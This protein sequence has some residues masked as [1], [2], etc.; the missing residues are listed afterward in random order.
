MVKFYIVLQMVL[1]L[2]QAVMSSKDNMNHKEKRRVSYL[3]HGLDVTFILGAALL[4]YKM[5][6]RYSNLIMAGIGFSV[7]GDLIMSEALKLKNRLVFG[8]ASFSATHFFYISAFSR[9]IGDYS[10]TSRCVLPYTV[11]T[12]LIITSIVFIWLVRVPS[13][14]K[15]LN[16]SAFIYGLIVSLMAASG[17]TA[18]ITLGG[19]WS[20]LGP[21]TGL[22]LFSDAIIALTEIGG[23]KIPKAGWLI[24]V[25]YSAAQVGIIIAGLL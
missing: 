24:W 23:H 17:C 7:L 18:A 16:N 22:F 3:R 13:A 15:I 20:I 11:G 5:P 2:I 10:T 1:F 9:L 8:M 12:Y 25:T 21:A 19:G 6:G 4:M 14:G